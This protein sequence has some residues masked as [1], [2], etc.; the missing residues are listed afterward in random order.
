MIYTFSRVGKFHEGGLEGVARGKF[1]EG[2]SVNKDSEF[3]KNPICRIFYVSQIFFPPQNSYNTTVSRMRNVFSFHNHSFV[4]PHH[5]FAKPV[6][7]DL[8]LIPFLSKILGQKKFAKCKNIGSP[9]LK[10]F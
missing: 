2:K 6:F 5:G 4:F 3:A 7:L 10:S 8:L 1:Y 9:G